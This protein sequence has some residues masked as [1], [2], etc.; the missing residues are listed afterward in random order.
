MLFGHITNLIWEQKSLPAPLLKG[1][2][3]LQQTDFTKVESGRYELQGESIFAIVQE[4][5]TEPKSQRQAETHQKYI[6]IQF[7]AS[8]EEVIGYAPIDPDNKIL[9]DRLTENDA[10]FYR[11]VKAEQDLTLR[12]GNYAIFFPSDI[13]RPCCQV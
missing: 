8:G 4:Y 5:Q 9:E 3:Y 7:I 1:L 6:D 10:L 12:V 13:H 2:T 11:T